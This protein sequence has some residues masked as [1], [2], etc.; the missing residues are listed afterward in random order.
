MR[1][2]HVKTPKHPH[3]ETLHI[4]SAVLV[5]PHTLRITFADGF[6]QTI[7]FKPFF[8]KHSP[9]EDE[10]LD[11]AVFASFT[12]ESDGTL[13]WNNFDLIFPPEALRLGNIL[14]KIIFPSMAHLT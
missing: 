11:P 2:R 9:R 3:P 1:I 5:A 7:D 13:H 10:Y 14:D 6:E 4:V 8:L 12:L